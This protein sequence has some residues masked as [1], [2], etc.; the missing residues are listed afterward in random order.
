M[1]NKGRHTNAS[2]FF[3]TFQPTAWMDFRYVAFGLVCPIF[4]TTSITALCRQL[5]EG[6]HTL[7]AMERVP[8]KNERPCKEIKITEIKV[9]EPKDIHSKIR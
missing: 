6:C 7:D 9:L 2:Q 1:A 8:T 4:N 3:I 5:L